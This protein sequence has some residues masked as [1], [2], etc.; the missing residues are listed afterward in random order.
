MVILDSSPPPLQPAQ[1]PI[2][3]KLKSSCLCVLRQGLAFSRENEEAFIRVHLCCMEFL[4][5][6]YSAHY[7]PSVPDVA[8]ALDKVNKLFL[9]VHSSTVHASTTCFWMRK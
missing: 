4:N 7:T 8:E 6:S 5:A 2:Q 3:S 1:V 9:C